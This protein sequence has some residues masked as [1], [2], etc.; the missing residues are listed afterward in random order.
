MW[1]VL[2]SLEEKSICIIVLFLINIVLSAPLN[3]YSATPAEANEIYQELLN[4]D[5]LIF[6]KVNYS[7][8]LI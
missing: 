2:Y 4:V 7:K 6:Y 5:L 3:I 8:V 1:F